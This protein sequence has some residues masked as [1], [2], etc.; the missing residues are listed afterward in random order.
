MISFNSQIMDKKKHW[1]NIYKTKEIN[2]V[3]WYQSIPQ[4][5][6]DLISK[7]SRSKNEKIIDV[8]CGK[9]FLVDNLL[10][11]GFIDISLL[12]I[13]IDALE[14]VSKRIGNKKVKCIEG[15]ILNVNLKNNFDIWHDRA[16]FHF[17]TER[18]GIKKYVSIC[19]EKINRNGTL[20]IGTF[21]EDGPL[22]CSGLE[23]KRYSIKNLKEIFKE[24]F[25]FVEGFKKLHSTPFDTQQSFTFC[26]FKKFANR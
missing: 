24:N 17:I 26:V 21:A 7:F 25:E 4:E 20:I 2:G 19:N 9:G 11:L 23:I 1:E 22:K 5:S 12:D 16:V 14:E 6:I 10:K 18:E 8:G 15:D 13:S 3:S